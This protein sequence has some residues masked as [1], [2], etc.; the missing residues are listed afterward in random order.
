MLADALA[1]WTRFLRSGSRLRSVWPLPSPPA[2][3]ILY[4][5][6]EGSGGVGAVLF[7]PDYS[8]SWWSGHVPNVVRRRLAAACGSRRGCPIYLLEALVPIVCLRLWA[9]SL[10]S[11]PWLIFVDNTTALFALRKGSSRAPALNALCFQ[12]WELVRGACIVPCFAWVPTRFN[13]ADDPSRGR[14]PA[15]SSVEV[16]P[17]SDSLWH[18]SA[19]V[20]Y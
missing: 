3:V 4:T 8:S 1:W 11:R 16:A 20:A 10:G 6:A 17:P 7:Q 19:A 15:S 18:R 13:V 9:Q 12:F 5:D 14:P 2:P